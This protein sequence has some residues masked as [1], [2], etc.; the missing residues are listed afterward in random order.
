MSDGDRL[1]G[2]K[3]KLASFLY[4]PRTVPYEA[5]ALPLARLPSR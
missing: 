4:L 1:I 3:L 2:G 5:T